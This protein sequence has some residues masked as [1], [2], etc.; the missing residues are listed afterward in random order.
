MLDI[1]YSYS[2]S[3]MISYKNQDWVQVVATPYLSVTYAVINAARPLLNRTGVR[4]ALARAWDPQALK[5]VFQDYVLPI[6]SLL[7][8]GLL[9][10]GADEPP[11]RFFPG[12][13]PGRC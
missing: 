13:G 9:G 5:L 1:I 10:G 4:Q 3:K 6:H 11:F 12:Q 7:P 2:I 8:G